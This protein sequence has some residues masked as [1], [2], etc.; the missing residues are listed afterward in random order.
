M[1]G[2][3]FF[4][5]QKKIAD[6]QL[7]LFP[8][9][10][11]S[12]PEGYTPPPGKSFPPVSDTRILNRLSI[13]SLISTE[14]ENL[15]LSTPSSPYQL[16][17]FSITDFCRGN[18]GSTESTSVN[19][20]VGCIFSI[21]RKQFTNNRKISQCPKLNVSKDFNSFRSQCIKTRPLIAFSCNACDKRSNA[22]S[23]SSISFKSAERPSTDSFVRRTCSKSS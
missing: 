3:N 4:S 16:T 12:H 2:N 19:F 21:S 7:L 13:N 11:G 18:V 9:C 5:K 8:I 14:S 20:N 15:C 22:G 23:N 10:I 17:C 1:C 6:R